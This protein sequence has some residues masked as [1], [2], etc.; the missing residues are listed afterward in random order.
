MQKHH[1][2]KCRDSSVQS[3]E[4]VVVDDGSTDRTWR[5]VESYGNCVRYL[6][7]ANTGVSSS[8]NLAK[9]LPLLLARRRTDAGNYDKVRANA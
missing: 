5:V 3:R 8:R 9:V 6:Y 1:P 2:K 4:I 7:Q